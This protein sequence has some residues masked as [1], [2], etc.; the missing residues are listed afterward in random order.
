VFRHRTDDEA[1]RHLGRL[2]WSFISKLAFDSAIKELAMDSEESVACRLTGR[3]P[4]RSYNRLILVEE[5][6][7]FVD[8]LYLVTDNLDV[9]SAPGSRWNYAF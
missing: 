8:V 2:E 9:R 1:F 6:D 4:A 5:V 3:W 7:C